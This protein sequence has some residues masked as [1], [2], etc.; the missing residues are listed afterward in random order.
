[1]NGRRSVHIYE[2]TGFIELRASLH[3]GG[4]GSP[5]RP[6][7][8]PLK[9]SSPR[10][11][12]S[13]RL[14]S[15]CL[16]VVRDDDAARLV[17]HRPTRA[18]RADIDASGI[19]Q[20]LNART[21]LIWQGRVERTV[22][23]VCAREQPRGLVHGVRFVGVRHCVATLL[24]VDVLVTVLAYAGSLPWLT[25]EFARACMLPGP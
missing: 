16:L 6:S 25:L 3:A 24:V 20:R 19:Q 12:S 22:H 7:E 9:C 13:S 15:I 14:L 17:V 21:L 18:T 1:M 2:S 10:I 5:G 23:N 8:A 11:S 4:D